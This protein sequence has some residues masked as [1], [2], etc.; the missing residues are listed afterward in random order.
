M[1]IKTTE[2]LFEKGV[3]IK[4]DAT[5]RL[6]PNVINHTILV[7]SSLLAILATLSD[8]ENHDI[9]LY[10]FLLSSL[11]ISIVSGILC[12]AILT[13]D[14]YLLGKKAVKEAKRINSETETPIYINTGFFPYFLILSTFSA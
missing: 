1:N 4:S 11:L 14:Y 5:S 13:I 3:A 9:C 2:T 6:L 10:R 8:P 12:M 7:A